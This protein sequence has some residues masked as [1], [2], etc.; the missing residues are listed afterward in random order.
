M[1]TYFTVEIQ[2]V[3]RRQCWDGFQPLGGNYAYHTVSRIFPICTSTGA[4][5]R[6][7]EW[8]AQTQYRAQMDASLTSPAS[9]ENILRLGAFYACL[10]Q[11]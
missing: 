8:Y 6:S 4:H 7:L 9:V 10:L 5:L 1:L 3:F 11:R 2:D